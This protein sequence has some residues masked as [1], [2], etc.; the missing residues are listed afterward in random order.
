LVANPIVTVEVGTEKFRARAE[1]VYGSE[2]TRLL[3]AA[4]ELLPLF[5]DYQNKT[6]REIPVLTLTRID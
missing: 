3:N 4:A 5:A 6:K 1:Q 2:R